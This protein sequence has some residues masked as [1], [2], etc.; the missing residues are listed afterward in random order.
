MALIGDGPFDRMA[1]G[2]AGNLTNPPDNQLFLDKTI[3]NCRSL[4]ELPEDFLFAW[5]FLGQSDKVKNKQS[6]RH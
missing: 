6:I 5:T 1:G 4:Q 3:P 2:Q